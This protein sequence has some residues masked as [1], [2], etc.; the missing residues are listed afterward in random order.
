MKRFLLNFALFAFLSVVLYG[1][2]AGALLWAELHAYARESH[3]PDDVTCVVCGDSQTETGLLAP[4]WPHFFNFS[5]SSLQLDQVELKVID[6]LERNPDFRGT[7]IIDMSPMKL[8]DQDLDKSMLVD[9][10]SGKRFLLHALH[11]DRSRRPLD[12]VVILFRDSI[13]VKRTT[14]ALQCIRKGCPY[15][16]SIGGMG[17]VP[18]L[19]EDAAA[20]NRTRF[21][22][23]PTPC[24][25][26]EH[27]DL[28]EEGMD[29]AATELDRWG[30]VD[31]DSKSVR[32]LR[33]ILSEIR[34]HGARPVMITTPIHP[35]LLNRMPRNKLEN[36]KATLQTVAKAEKVAYFSYLKE[37]FPDGEWRDGNHLNFRGAVR[38]TEMVR[39]D[40]ESGRSERKEVR[41]GN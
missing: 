37:E 39:E 21:L 17:A 1:G 29:E 19:T 38:L 34:A 32:C 36:F 27:P 41:Y 7:V 8:F 12:G 31:A 23:M 15:F 16:S 22:S 2:W 13:L 14:K 26:A 11:P 40:V 10:S 9:R 5:I 4:T 20:T 6:L 30:L 25:F 24:G 28:V 18:G 33:D 35:R 3:L